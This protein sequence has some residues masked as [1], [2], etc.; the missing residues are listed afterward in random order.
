MRGETYEIQS[1]L[2][3]CEA[4]QDR[5]QDAVK[6]GIGAGIGAIVGGVVGGGK[7]AAIGAVAGGSGTVLATKGKE[8]QVTPGTIV[9]ALLQE[10]VTVTVPFK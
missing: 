5:R 3:T 7:G 4:A 1:A 10:A 2:I 6:G 8:V 9:T